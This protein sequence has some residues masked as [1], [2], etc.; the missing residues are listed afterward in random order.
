[1]SFSSSMPCP[2]DWRRKLSRL[3]AR[4]I[5]LANATRRLHS[6]YAQASL[7]NEREKRMVPGPRALLFLIALVAPAQAACPDNPVAL[8]PGRVPPVAPAPFP[9]A[10]PNDFPN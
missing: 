2:F 8:G 4:S 9:A 5:A 10:A 7:V 1:M 6:R 3:Y